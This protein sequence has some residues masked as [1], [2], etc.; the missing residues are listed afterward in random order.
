MLEDLLNERRAPI[1][2]LDYLTKGASYGK[3]DE[4]GARTL[5]ELDAFLV[6]A[7]V[8]ADLVQRLQA[9]EAGDV[10]REQVT[11]RLAA[12]KKQC[13]RLLKLAN[14]GD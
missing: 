5:S 12:L 11:G 13:T 2:A 10:P 9:G 3:A 14:A 6:Q 7:Q 1:R 4:E 8:T